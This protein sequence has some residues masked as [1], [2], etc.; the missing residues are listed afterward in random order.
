MAFGSVNIGMHDKNSDTILLEAPPSET[1]KGK[2]GQLALDTNSRV[3]YKCVM[4][5]P[6]TGYTWE[7]VFDGGKITKDLEMTER[8]RLV[9]TGN[10]GKP[11]FFVMA[12]DG[13]MFIGGSVPRSTVV[14]TGVATPQHDTD[15]A[16]KQYVDQQI[17]ALRAEIGKR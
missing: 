8:T 1:T 10:D 5:S 12:N 9:F 3:L 14:I 6:H 11:V 13:H 15:A 4:D 16:N 7:P 17:A 2:V